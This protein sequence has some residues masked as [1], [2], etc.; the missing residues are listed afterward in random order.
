MTQIDP[1]MARVVQDRQTY[2]IIGCAM[3]V[4]R[5]L[6]SRFLEPVYQAALEREFD[7]KYVPFVREVEPKVLYKGRPLDVK[8][9]ADFICFSGEVLVELKATDRLSER[10]DSQ[11]INYLVVSQIGRGLLLNF[12]AS[13]LQYRRFVH[14]GVCAVQSAK[15][16]ES[17]GPGSQGTGGPRRR[18]NP[19]AAA[20]VSPLD[21]LEKRAMFLQTT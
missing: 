3:E 17:V 5:Q 8:Y 1:S 7:A 18:R 16:A 6:G 13:S 14:S 19:L 12:G 2:L 10:D 4:H 9:R 20:G 11:V 15:S 21:R